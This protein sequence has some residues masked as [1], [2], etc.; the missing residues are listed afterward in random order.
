MYIR[1]FGVDC[2]IELLVAVQVIDI[3]SRS[4]LSG[5]GEPDFPLRKIWL[6]VMF[7][8]DCFRKIL[9]KG[10][11][12]MPLDGFVVRNRYGIIDIIDGGGL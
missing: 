1:V 6:G 7:H 9:L 11:C 2:E 5:Y 8:P 12:P 3:G 10:N 4:D